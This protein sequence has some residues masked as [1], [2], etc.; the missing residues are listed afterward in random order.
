MNDDM[1]LFHGAKFGK[2][3]ST[4]TNPIANYQSTIGNII[5]AK[6]IESIQANQWIRDLIGVG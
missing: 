5:L 4:Q 6:F 2:N 3:E 1:K